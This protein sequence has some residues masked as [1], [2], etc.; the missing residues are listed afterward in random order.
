MRSI[1]LSDADNAVYNVAG[2]AL[3]M[4]CPLAWPCLAVL[5]S[6]GKSPSRLTRTGNERGT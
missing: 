4:A 1:A 2:C 5:D 6:S 3:T